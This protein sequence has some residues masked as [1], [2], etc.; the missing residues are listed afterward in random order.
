VDQQHFTVWEVIVIVAA[1]TAS[2]HLYAALAQYL[3]MRRMVQ[4]IAGRRAWIAAI[5]TGSRV[6]AVLLSWVVGA[7]GRRWLGARFRQLEVALERLS[8]PFLYYAETL[9]METV[10]VATVFVAVRFRL[11]RTSRDA[12]AG[13]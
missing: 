10:V 7:I 5:L 8:V 13:S 3:L 6:A 4:R 1:A 12:A 9:A 2:T 11:N